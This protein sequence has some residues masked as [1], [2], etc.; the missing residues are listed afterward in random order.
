MPNPLEQL[1]VS[2]KDIA[3]N[4]RKEARAKKLNYR[5]QVRRLKF[6]SGIVDIIGNGPY[7]RIWIG[8]DEN[9]PCTVSLNQ[10]QVLEVMDLYRDALSP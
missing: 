10:K 4:R 5:N 2:E 7:T 9:S 3:R 8:P 1:L 6:G